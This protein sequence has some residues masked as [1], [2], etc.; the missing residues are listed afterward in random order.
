LGRGVT[1]RVQF[2]AIRGLDERLPGREVP[3]DRSDADAGVFRDLDEGDL[4]A[5]F[6]EQP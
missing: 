6:D 1:H 3:V 5:S 4:R 2:T